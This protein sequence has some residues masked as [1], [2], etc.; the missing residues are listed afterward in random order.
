M[1]RKILVVFSI[2]LFVTPALQAQKLDFLGLKG[3]HFGMK[4]TEIS[5]KVVV[6]DSTSIYKDTAVYIRNNR[7]LTYFRKHENFALNGFTATSLQYEFCDKELAYI[8]VT[9]NGEKEI[10]KSLNQLKVTFRKLGCKGK[11]LSECTQIDSSA[12]GMRI[13][14]NIDRKN[15]RM[16]FV[17]IP[18]AAAK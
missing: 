9:V 13:I 2:F 5:D 6:M 11:S 10:E 3:Y 16:S 15:Q 4:D 7:C 17:L 8:F 1:T 12:K 18:K 14:I